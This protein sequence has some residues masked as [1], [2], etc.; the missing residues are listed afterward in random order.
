MPEIAEAQALMSALAASEAVKDDA[1]RRQRL[2]QLQVSYGNALIAARGFGAPE[3]TEAFPRARE[4][5]YGKEDAL[6]R[7]AADYGLWASSYTRGDLPS[8]R[9]HAATFLRDVEAKPESPEAGI[10]HRV[11]GIT[12]WSAGEFI[13]AKRHLERALAL[14][15]PGRDDDL[16]FRF[17]LDVGVATFANLA[18]SVWALGDPECATSL[19]SSMHA[20]VDSLT[21][22][23]TRAF[24]KMT[25]C[26]FAL[27]RRDLRSLAENAFDLARLVREH[28]L[29]M[30]RGPAL[31]LE[32]WADNVASASGDGL[33]KMRRGLELMR[34]K[35][36]L[37]RWIAENCAF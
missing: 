1:A 29:T 24:G 34:T 15:E 14:F 12:C 26:M 11:T 33:D 5:A 13:E 28:D 9:M 27:M 16:A 2:T 35:R 3:T 23:S 32:A 20:R 19:M 37:V 36:L 6:E 25:A 31:F 18:I 17:G 4:V 10:A 30:F 21:H 22:V 8:M 7:L